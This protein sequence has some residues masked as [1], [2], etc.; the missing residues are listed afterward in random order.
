MHAE[1]EESHR[2]MRSLSDQATARGRTASARCRPHAHGL[3]QQSLRGGAMAEHTLE[4]LDRRAGGES[5]QKAE[6]QGQ[7]NDGDNP[8][9]KHGTKRCH[10]HWE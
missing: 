1:G 2:R 3:S 8:T 5:Q 6:H 4:H 9:D 7:P 10:V